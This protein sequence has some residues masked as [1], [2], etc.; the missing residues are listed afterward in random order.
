MKGTIYI[1]GGWGY[2]NRGDNAILAGM[3]ESFKGKLDKMD[4]LIT[5]YDQSELSLQNN[6][7]SIQSIHKLLTKKLL[8]NAWHRF[9]YWLWKKS[10]HKW[11]LSSALNKHLEILKDADVMVLG[12]GGYF[13]DAWLDM[14]E[15]KYAEIEMAEAVNCP[16]MIYGQTIGPFSDETIKQSLSEKLKKIEFIAYRDVQSV[17]VLEKCNF[18]M[19]KSALTADEANLLPKYGKKQFD[20]HKGKIILGVMIQNF[21]PHLHMTGQ[22]VGGSIL[23][24]HQYI[25]EVVNALNSLTSLI[26]CHLVFITSTEWD[27]KT[28][29]NVYD[30]LR[31]ENGST[32]EFIVDSKTDNFINVC[33]QVDVML[34]TNMHP[35]ILAS[36]GHK[37]SVALSYH[38]KL[39]D[40]M[41]SVGQKDAV[42]R[43][44]NFSGDTL[45]ALLSKTIA[46]RLEI[47][48][49]V[50]EQH[51]K[52]QELAARNCEAL[53]NLLN[54]RSQT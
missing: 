15:S 35:I 38:Y 2:G 16:V 47:G 12:G 18:N 8:K 11:M 7:K 41:E 13:N 21:R 50:A 17:R 32:K 36:T 45:K 19:A 27:V 10:K 20:E 31:L 53:I 37:P 29:R 39:D 43:I 26:A 49:T 23:N 4:L 42:L 24:K 9:S 22:S 44:D 33:Q 51:K 48:V 52:V 28:N 46:N 5:S 25:K 34:S 1:S 40:Y 6:V 3:L 54:K 14:L 30:K